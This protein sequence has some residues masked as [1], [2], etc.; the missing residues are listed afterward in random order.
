MACY[1]DMKTLNEAA[2]SKRYQEL[3][4]QQK[5]AV[6]TIYGPVMVIAG[7]GTGKTEVLAMRIAN[8]LRSDAQVKPH[9]ILCLTFTDEGAVAMRT[10]LLS[11]VGEQAHKINIYTFHSFCNSIIQSQTEYFGWRDLQPISDLEKMDLVYDIIENLEQGHLLRKL[12]GNL[13]QDAKSLIK[14]FSLMKTEDWPPQRVN[15]AIDSYLK[16]L[17]ENE[18]YIYKRGNDKAGIKAG[19][20]KTNDI[21]QETKRMERTRAAAMLYPLYDERMKA[22]GWYDFDDMILWVL[23]A[24][25]ER[26]EFLQSQQER[27]QFFFG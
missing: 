16:S 18:K 15:D 17:P 10:R 23:K 9:E 21:E 11:I 24:F 20:P 13:H 3:N 14:F 19:D 26:P 5:E 22:A 2:F 7:P 1:Y 8:L 27:F 12:K 25:K 4:P 6:D